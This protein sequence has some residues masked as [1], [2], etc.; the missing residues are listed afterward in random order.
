[1]AS[2]LGNMA[3]VVKDGSLAL[4]TGS[5]TEGQSYARHMAGET[6]QDIDVMVIEGCINSQD[7]LIP[8]CP[9]FV[10][11]RF[12]GVQSIDGN[13]LE[14]KIN[15]SGIACVN[16]Q[17]MKERHSEQSTFDSVPLSRVTFTGKTKP[18]SASVAGRTFYQ[19]LQLDKQF[20]EQLANIPNI[21]EQHRRNYPL[22][23]KGFLKSIGQYVFPLLTN[24]HTFKQ[25]NEWNLNEDFIRDLISLTG[26]AY[27]YS[28]SQVNKVR[29]IALL[30]FYEKYK[31]L[32]DP[33]YFTNQIEYLQTCLPKESDIVPSLQLKFWPIDVLPFLHRLRQTSLKLYNLIC[34]SNVSMHVIPKWSK[35]TPKIDREIEFRYS[36]SYIERLLAENRS[37]KERIL[38]GV[39]RSIYYHYLKG[40][41]KSD[42][43]DNLNSS[44]EVKNCESD[45][46][47]DLGIDHHSVDSANTDSKPNS[48][49]IPSYFVKTTVLWMCETQN[50]DNLEGP[51]EI[52]QQWLEFARKCLKKRECR[53]YFIESINILE[54]C[55]QEVLDEAYNIL[56][57]DVKL[58]EGVDLNILSQHREHLNRFYDSHGRF[59]I[60][61]SDESMLNVVEAYRLL[62]EQWLYIGS[63]EI[64]CS[65]IDTQECESI[66]S[67]LRLIDGDNLQNWTEFR[68]I[69]L[70][71]DSV[72]CAM[73]PL[74]GESVSKCSPSEFADSLMAIG[75]LLK[76]V[77]DA[78]SDPKFTG[79][80]VGCS[81][82]LFESFKNVA[83]DLMNPA[84]IQHQ[85]LTTWA[86][87]F[88]ANAEMLSSFINRTLIQN[89]GQ[90]GA[91]TNHQLNP[92][93][94][95]LNSFLSQYQSSNT[96]NEVQTNTS[97][98]SQ[99]PQQS[100][101]QHK[102]S[103]DIEEQ[104][105]EFAKRQSL[106]FQQDDLD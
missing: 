97:Q 50:I 20:Q 76:A 90:G 9:G 7:A 22:F 18:D 6:N 82:N 69:F 70:D 16:G 78:V 44:R 74:W 34:N 10:H 73:E 72:D 81:P 32:G 64:P 84:N 75:Y 106:G 55:P 23:C 91:T 95:M 63:S 101:Q 46:D 83:R 27:G 42:R 4:V 87:M 93:Q 67:T 47:I 30:D 102:E 80:C 11:I 61:A 100:N 54:S 19:T 96:S 21:T 14:A 17:K 43:K 59:H 37:E 38:N 88:G 33:K 39:A 36:F 28:L 98:Q 25:M 68:R 58:E 79:E 104:L 85:L 77:Y 66:L 60:K 35:K 13:V 92:I 65:G 56:N 29:L 89:L 12:D 26:P 40:T 5:T 48:S 53:H 103:D 52:A 99:S 57:N 49:K 45:D 31:K 24:I 94:S 3:T 41:K 62:K 15:Q 51:K 1:M 71:K 2:S 105:I 86:P 8:M